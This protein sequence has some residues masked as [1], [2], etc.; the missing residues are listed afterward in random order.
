[1]IKQTWLLLA[2]GLQLFDILLWG[3]EKIDFCK[4]FSYPTIEEIV[5]DDLPTSLRIYNQLIE[6]KEMSQCYD[7]IY[8]QALY[9]IMYPLSLI[10]ANKGLQILEKL[11]I[12]DKKKFPEVK[13]E[14]GYIITDG[15]PPGMGEEEQSWFKKIA[16][17]SGFCE[18]ENDIVFSNDK[19]K[20]KLKPFGCCCKPQNL[21]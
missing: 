1:M 16:V 9:R 20:F 15:I 12:Y 13:I 2:L 4:N 21:E 5:K 11:K 10:D 6:K 8:V 14:D 17:E 7:E 3:Q 18:S 19:I